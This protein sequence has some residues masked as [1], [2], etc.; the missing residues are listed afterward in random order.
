MS[1]VKKL[2]VT[3]I[4][5]FSLLL[6]AWFGFNSL[7]TGLSILFIAIVNL[8][9]SWKIASD[10]EH[11]KTT[12]TEILTQFSQQA[13]SRQLIKLE[14]TNHDPLLTN[15]LAISDEFND[16]LQTNQSDKKRLYTYQQ[17]LNNIH[18]P[19]II[20][21]SQSEIEFINTQAQKVLI[22]LNKQLG[23]V[24]EKIDDFYG[25]Q[26][27][28]IDKRLQLDYIE[29]SASSN[30]WIEMLLEDAIYY[31]SIKKNRDKN[32]AVIGYAVICEDKTEEVLVSQEVSDVISRVTEGDFSLEVNTNNLHDVTKQLGLGIN[33]IIGIN[34]KIITN[35][36]N[37]ME[38]IESGKLGCKVEGEYSGIF[39][40]LQT[41][42]NN[43]V[44]KIHTMIEKMVR[45]AHLLESSSNEIAAGNLDLSKRTEKQS[46]FLSESASSMGELAKI[47]KANA[48]QANQVVEISEEARSL[49]KKSGEV[50]SHT[51]QAM[52]EINNRSR[53]IGDIIGVINDI[54]FQTNLLA[55][56]AAV[57]AA[58]AGE[59]GRGFAVVATEVRNLSKRTSEA[60]KE[61]RELIENS[62]ESVKVG[63]HLVNESGNALEEIVLVANDVSE[64]VKQMATQSILQ[65]SGIDEVNKN[66]TRINEA[67]K[68][69]A[70]LVQEVA[71]ASEAMDN[72]VKVLE[73]LM[74]FF[75]ID[76]T[77]PTQDEIDDE[78]NDEHIDSLPAENNMLESEA[79][80]NLS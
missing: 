72:E 62:V 8:L 66:L 4:A 9:I 56:N 24:V 30:K 14:I 42:V 52:D 12:A 65:S 45:A 44:E 59:H 43:T 75:A 25:K 55:L 34:K 47:V 7:W 19:L 27:N 67:N 76:S 2:L 69:N 18:L 63:V 16:L 57:E 6:M 61:I 3:N 41:H 21:N 73:D 32:D 77:L 22:Q 10:I 48:D 50:V 26:I 35:T 74:K 31:L 71:A 17:T 40:K 38:Q 58:R 70:A 51:V 13:S 46:M 28:L 11:Q 5:S 53:K 37:V 23:N 39:E 68:L 36:V 60:A 49:A 78:H 15:I 64:R 29:K 54:A 33:K 79:R 1:L 20:L 80:D